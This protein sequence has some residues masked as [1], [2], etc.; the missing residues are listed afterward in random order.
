VLGAAGHRDLVGRVVEPIVPLE[1]LAHGGAQL[2]HPA[3]LRIFR[4]AL[5]DRANGRVL[6]APRRI[7]VRFARAEGDHVDPLRAHGLGLRLH[8]ERG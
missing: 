7:E 3:D 5:L 8:G 1:L 6:D 2:G 4:L